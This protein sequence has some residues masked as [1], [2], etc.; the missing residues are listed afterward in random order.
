VRQGPGGQRHRLRPNLTATATTGGDLR[1]PAFFVRHR[2]AGRCRDPG[3]RAE[4]TGL[5]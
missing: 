4:H 5:C 1:V 2:G 3:G